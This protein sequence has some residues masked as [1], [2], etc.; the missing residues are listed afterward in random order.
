MRVES[1]FD[2]DAINILAASDQHVLRAV[3]NE[4]E[5]FLVDTHEIAGVEPAIGDGGGGRL[6]LVP[7]AFD[8][9]RPFDPKLADL[10][11]RQGL[12]LLIDDLHIDD[13]H[14]WPGTFGPIDI[15]FRA[16]LR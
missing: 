7:I 14:A 12:A 8:D 9:I 5:A 2:L 13:G 15:I 4:D 10:T 11:G 6:G 3:E 1:A 16:V